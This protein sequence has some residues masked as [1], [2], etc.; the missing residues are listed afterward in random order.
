MA[1][2]NAR[3][4]FKKYPELFMKM[5]VHSEEERPGVGDDIG[6]I[7]SKIMSNVGHP[8]NYWMPDEADG[9]TKEEILKAFA[10]LKLPQE[11]E[12]VIPTK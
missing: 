3:E 7:Y 2:T 5:W 1:T 11:P 9:F 4:M 8:D 12:Q 6:V 10:E